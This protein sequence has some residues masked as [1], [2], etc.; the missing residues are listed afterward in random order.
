MD[1]MIRRMTWE[2]EHE[3]FYGIATP[4][5]KLMVFLQKLGVKSAVTG[6]LWNGLSSQLRK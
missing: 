4:K 5:K 1:D 2:I 6:T 3:L